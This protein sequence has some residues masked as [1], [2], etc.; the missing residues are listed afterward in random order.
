MRELRVFQATC[1]R[2]GAESEVVFNESDPG[3]P[4]G[5]HWE[6]KDCGCHSY[7]L[8]PACPTRFS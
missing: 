1:D 2:C 8:C 3:L 4:E 7:T 5:W 6:S